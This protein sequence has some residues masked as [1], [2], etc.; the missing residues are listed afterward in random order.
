MAP[1]ERACCV[2]ASPMASALP[3]RLPWVLRCPSCGT[4]A[5]TLDVRINEATH[6]DLDEDLREDGL[7]ELRHRNNE[8][9]LDRVAAVRAVAG[10]RLLDVGAA[11]GWFVSAA[12][13]RGAT[14][15]GIEPDEDVAAR[16]EPGGGELRVGF[17]PDALE[18]GEQFDVISFN[19]VL[20]HLPDPS[21]V[22]AE[23]ARRLVPGGVLVLNLPTSTGLLFKIA[24]LSARMGATALLARLW[25]A[26]LPSPHLWYFDPRGLTR[27][28]ERHGFDV[29]HEG[30]L[31]AVSRR[32]LWGRVHSDRKVSPLTL[33]TV[34]G[35]TLSAPMLNS[36]RTSDIALLLFVRRG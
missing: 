23:C 32:G 12:A 13:A 3:Q 22:I 33:L 18:A 29:V 27:L 10:A 34:A 14:A 24:K 25:Q 30:R 5:S 21:S 9:I 19:D 31:P 11:H 35:V 26:G 36:R 4:W 6:R 1:D 28:A 7:R 20:E 16:S 8:L 15:L 17:F 2:C